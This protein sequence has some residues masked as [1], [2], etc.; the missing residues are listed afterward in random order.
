M[1]TE[2]SIHSPYLY[3]WYSSLIQIPE[4]GHLHKVNKQY[5]TEKLGSEFFYNTQGQ[6]KSVRHIIRYEVLPTPWLYLLV[7]SAHFIKAKQVLELGTSVGLTTSAL[8]SITSVEYIISFEQEESLVR[9]AEELF[10]KNSIHSKIECCIGDITQILRPYLERLKESLDFVYVDANHKAEPTLQYIQQI[11][12]FLSQNAWI[13]L[14]DINYSR[15]MARTWN[16][17]KQNHAF[18]TS[19]DLYRFGVLIRNPDL[20]YTQ[21]ALKPPHVF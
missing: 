21:I 12:P 1:K 16:L 18:N 10:H 20:N 5:L 8:A 4:L 3:A 15:D 17:L 7:Q 2:H 19:I 6:K 13:V 14:D 11:I 9:I